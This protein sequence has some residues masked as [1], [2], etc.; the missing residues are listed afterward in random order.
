MLSHAGAADERPL[1]RHSPARWTRQLHAGPCRAF[2]ATPAMRVRVSAGT[3]HSLPSPHKHCAG[4]LSQS[5]SWMQGLS[6]RAHAS[7]ATTQVRPGCKPPPFQRP[8]A[9]FTTK[10]PLPPNPCG[11]GH[12]PCTHAI[13]VEKGVMGSLSGATSAAM[14]A[15]RIMKLV[16]QVS[17]SISSAAAPSSSASCGG[18]VC[19]L[20]GGRRR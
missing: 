3:H 4:T 9:L 8:V 10:T 5:R 6:C 11:L 19:G 2:D 16:A 15:S 13:L 17:S 12:A 18:G 1:C 14:R 7:T 20:G